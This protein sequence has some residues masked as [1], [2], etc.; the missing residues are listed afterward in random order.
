MVSMVDLVNRWL[1]L[2]ALDALGL[3][4]AGEV[5]VGGGHLAVGH[6][7]PRLQQ[8][9]LHVRLRVQVRARR[10]GGA[11][12]ELA[13]ALEDGVGDGLGRERHNQ[14]LLRQGRQVAD[15]RVSLVLGVVD[16]DV[17]AGDGVVLAGGAL[18][19]AHLELGLGGGGLAA[20]GQSI[21]VPRLRL[22]HHRGGDVAGGDGSAL[23][24]EGH[25]EA[26]SAAAA[27]RDGA[28][29]EAALRLQPAHHLL[30]GLIMASTN[31]KLHL[32]YIVSL[33]VDLLPALSPNRLEV[34]LHGR[35]LVALSLGGHLLTPLLRISR[36][37]GRG[38]TNHGSGT[39]D[40]NGSRCV[41]HGGN[42]V[43]IRTHH[44][45][46]GSASRALRRDHASGH[47]GAR[48]HGGAGREADLRGSDGGDCGRH[49]L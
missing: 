29:L 20:S 32:V 23:H 11:G 4:E 18:E 33:A 48:G 19:V 7:P 12:G 34:V 26:A 46:G 22:T 44:H 40:G 2:G 3:E 41:R 27:V 38:E 17:E 43:G 16:H 15:H 35:H 28:V 6:L 5:E 42:K 1:G 49:Y 13:D 8:R 31:V 30:H 24:G 45:L 36:N 21:L 37:E 14:A 39:E 9:R 25:R 47:R 10:L